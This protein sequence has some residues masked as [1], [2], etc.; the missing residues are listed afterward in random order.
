MP[1]R[2]KRPLGRRIQA[3]MMNVVNIPMRRILGL[4]FPT[5]LG[6]RLM[7][8]SLTGRRTGRSRSRLASQPPSWSG[9]SMIRTRRAICWRRWAA[10]RPWHSPYT[11]SRNTCTGCRWP[12]RNT[13]RAKSA[14]S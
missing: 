13:A 9:V 11:L 4:P 8:A 12:L 7:L 3:R 1:T 10:V 6:G 2:Q 14:L 5:P